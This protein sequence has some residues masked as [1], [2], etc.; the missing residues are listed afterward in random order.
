MIA[1][2]A[3][4]FYYIRLMKDLNRL[5]EVLVNKKVKQSE[6]AS[7]LGKN[8]NTVS[9]WSTN[10]RQPSVEDLD[11]IAIFLKVDIS[12]LLNPTEF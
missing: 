10:K 4:F 6:L 7:A 12:E 5:K 9:K 1:L 8:V 3:V 11:K 2:F